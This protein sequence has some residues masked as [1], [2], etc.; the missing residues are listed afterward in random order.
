ML[1]LSLTG[2]V[3][4][5]F[6][7]K[8]EAGEPVLSLSLFPDFLAVSSELQPEA[9][10]VGVSSAKVWPRG[11][12]NNNPGN[13][14]Y[15][16]GT[17]WDGLA[18]PPH[19]GDYCIFSNVRYGIRAMARVLGSYSR[20]GVVTIESIISTWAPDSENNTRAYISAVAQR[21]GFSAGDVLSQKEWPVLIE[22]IIH[23]ENGLQPYSMQVIKE[24]VALA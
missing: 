5:G 3:V 16:S 7:R 10:P 6:Y 8:A 11:I 22:A 1:I 4:W 13:I 15:N 9:F 2:L 21:T 17:Q 18:D 14:R 20:R 12:R 24:G 23:H 19:D